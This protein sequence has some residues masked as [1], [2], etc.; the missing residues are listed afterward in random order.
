[1]K[2]EDLAGKKVLDLGCGWT[3]LRRDLAKYGVVADVVSADIRFDDPKMFARNTSLRKI[4]VDSVRLPEFFPDEKFDVIFVSYFLSIVGEVDYI[5]SLQGMVD[6]LVPG[7]AAY[8]YPGISEE[9]FPMFSD[10]LTSKMGDKRVS[11]ACVRKRSID[12]RIIAGSDRLTQ[13]D[14]SQLQTNDP[15][16]IVINDGLGRINV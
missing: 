10:W 12:P 9:S 14:I 3:D 5:A 7:G 8:I 4:A 15:T 11:L 2:P 13:K 16:L 6:V 1:M